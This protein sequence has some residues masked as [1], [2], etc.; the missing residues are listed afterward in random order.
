[1]AAVSEYCFH[2]CQPLGSRQLMGRV[3]A[4]KEKMEKYPK[5]EK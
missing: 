3:R 5:E 1:M 2:F 4:L